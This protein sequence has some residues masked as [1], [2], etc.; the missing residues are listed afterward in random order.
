MSSQSICDPDPSSGGTAPRTRRARRW[1][2]LAAALAV[3]SLVAAACG[4]DSGS[5][6]STATT[7]A[8]AAPGASAAVAADSTLKALTIGFI[9]Q[10]AGSVGTYPETKVAIQAAVDYINKELGGVDKHPI[11]LDT[12]ATD[13]T[14]ASSQKCAEQMVNDKVLFVT[15][16]LDNNMQAWYPVLDPAGIPVIGG[17]PVA[18]ADFNA[19][20]G[21]FFVGGGATSYPGLA[22]YVL[23]F[24]PNAKKVGVL[25]NDTPGAAA[26][27]PLVRKPLEAAGVQVTDVKVPAS[28]A[29]WLAP[30]ASVKN[31]DAVLVLVGSANCISLAKARLSQQSTVPMVSVSACYSQATIDGAGEGGM[32][33]WRVTQNFEDPQGTSADAHTYQTVMKKYAPSGANLSGFAPVAFVDMMTMYVNILK[34]LGY[35]GS[36]LDKIVAKVKDPAGGKVFMGPTYKCGVA[37]APFVAICNYNTQWFSVKDGK[38]TDPTGF[39]DL[40]PTIKIANT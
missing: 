27:L 10:E 6:D 19:K 37:G 14:V 24:L 39:V 32:N 34:P 36:T 4:D 17:I 13:G 29:D 25:A 7:A 5:G 1:K 30:F 16:G 22:A 35:D 12:C 8:T 40:V 28:Q 18:G 2:V 31:M 38:L 9:N 21:S 26:A 15:G 23:K 11:K 3:S 33:G 20:N